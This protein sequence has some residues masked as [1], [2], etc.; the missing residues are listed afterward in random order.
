MVSVREDESSARHLRADK[1]CAPASAQEVLNVTESSATHFT[2]TRT[3]LGPCPLLSRDPETE[4]LM[5]VTCV[6]SFELIFFA[7]SSSRLYL[8]WFVAGRDP[9]TDPD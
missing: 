3:W 7:V 1:L 5:I 4:T 8:F 6:L 2:H 9:S